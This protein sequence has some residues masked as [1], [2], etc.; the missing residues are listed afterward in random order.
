[1]LPT[2]GLEAKEWSHLKLCC[3]AKVLALVQLHIWLRRRS[4]WQESYF[5]PRLHLVSI[6]GHPARMPSDLA[7]K[8]PSVCDA[9][10]GLMGYRIHPGHLYVGLCS[11]GAF[12]VSYQSKMAMHMT[13]VVIQG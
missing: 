12:T 11:S 6:F 1:M 3:M 2:L 8:G 9:F 10:S 13:K 5:T 4:N 7:A